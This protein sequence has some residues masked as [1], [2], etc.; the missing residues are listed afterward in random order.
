MLVQGSYV[1][2]SRKYRETSLLISLFTKDQGLIAAVA[3]GGMRGAT[4]SLLQ[5]FQP[6]AVTLSGQK[7]LPNLYKPELEEYLPPLPGRSL[8]AGLY[9]NE[10]LIHLCAEQD[11]HPTSYF[12][13]CQLLDDLRNEHSQIASHLRTFEWQVFSDTGYALDCSRDINDQPLLDN[14]TYWLDENWKFVVSPLG[15]YKGKDLTSISQRQFE[16]CPQIAKR[17]SRDIIGRIVGPYGLRSWKTF[18]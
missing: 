16:K 18:K 1:L 3:K 5:P 13:Y 14:T 8:I 4:Q 2:H 12:A 9:A 17:L 15:H 6:L 10:L 7:S 11:P